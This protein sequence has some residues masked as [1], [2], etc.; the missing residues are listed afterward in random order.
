MANLIEL[1]IRV[2]LGCGIAQLLFNLCSEPCQVS[3]KDRGGKYMHQRGTTDA[4]V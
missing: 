3:Y 1:P 4:L 2:Y